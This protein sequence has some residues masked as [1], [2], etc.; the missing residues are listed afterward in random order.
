MRALST[1]DFAVRHGESFSLVKG[2]LEEL[3]RFALLPLLS[4]CRAGGV[5]LAVIVEVGDSDPPPTLA[6]F[7]CTHNL[8]GSFLT[9]SLREDSDPRF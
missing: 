1:I 3:S 6:Y 9:F 7:H 8:F 5:E 4:S 2:Q